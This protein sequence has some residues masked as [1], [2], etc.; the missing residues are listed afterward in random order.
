MPELPEVETIARHLKDGGRGVPG[1]VGRTIER[2]E[3]FW[4]KTVEIPSAGQFKKQI[5]GQQVV[6]V[7]RRAK[8]ILLQ[9]S[10]DT[11]LVHLRM[12][13]DL[14]VGADQE[15][16]GKHIRLALF[17]DQNLQLAFNNPRKFGR[18]WLVSDPEE[19]LQGLGPEPL[20]EALSGQQFY[21]MLQKRKRHIKPLLMDQKFLAGVG[22]IYADEALNL[23]KIHPLTVSN[24]LSAEK[25]DTLLASIRAVLQEGIRRNGASIDWVYQGG[26]FQNYFRVYDQAGGSCP[27]C[28]T[29]IEK[30]VVAQRGT[31][32]C[33]ACQPAPDGVS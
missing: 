25:A 22:N 1:L 7:G 23:A 15:T 16:L 27:T 2:A 33:P 9:L 30:T 24:T 5:I 20:G 26:E 10:A 32:L 11:M 12:S 6:D 8:Y 21:Q 4:D 28:G 13:G 3:V 14:L 19:V 29:T 18:V 17:F 31:H